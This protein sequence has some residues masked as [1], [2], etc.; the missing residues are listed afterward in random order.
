MGSWLFTY[1]R[2]PYL[3]S[4]LDN[5]DYLSAYGTPVCARLEDFYD[6]TLVE[7]AILAGEL[8]GPDGQPYPNG[9]GFLDMYPESTGVF[10]KLAPYRVSNSTEEVFRVAAAAGTPEQTY[11]KSR[12]QCDVVS[13][14]FVATMGT[15]ALTCAMVRFGGHPALAFP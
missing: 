9:T 11:I 4:A 5:A 6:K 10:S 13:Y 14:L 7:A 15:Y 1:T 8:T 12:V 2:S 3:S